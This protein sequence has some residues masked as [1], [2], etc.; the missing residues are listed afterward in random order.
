MMATGKKSSCGTALH[1]TSPGTM[2]W[3]M[4]LL[5]WILSTGPVAALGESSPQV[6]D[7]YGTVSTYSDRRGQIP[8]NPFKWTLTPKT[9]A[10]EG[11]V[12][13]LELEAI[14]WSEDH[15]L[16]VINGKV[17]APGDEVEGHL[18]LEIDKEEV[19]VVKPSGREVVLKFKPILLPIL[20]PR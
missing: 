6:I 20:P 17:V 10:P 4:S 14:I 3:I 12:K 1:K 9:T 19:S 13:K 16:A 15:P 7:I 18:V 11:S 8:R 2:L 5:T